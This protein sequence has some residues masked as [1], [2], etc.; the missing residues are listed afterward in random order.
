MKKLRLLCINN[1]ATKLYL[2]TGFLGAGKTTFLKQFVHLFPREKLAILINE[3][4]KEDVDSQLLSQLKASMEEIHSG[5]IFCAC[6]LEQFE[7][8]LNRLLSQRP[9]TIIIETSGLS[10]PSNLREVLQD[11]RQTQEV[12]YRGCICVVDAVNFVKVYTTALAARKQISV[13]DT[14]VLNKIDM[15]VPESK[16]NIITAL[17][18]ARPAAPVMETSRGLIPASWK[19]RLLSPVLLPMEPSPHTRDLSVQ[20]YIISIDS[21]ISLKALQDFLHTF[22][23]VTHRI[24]GFVRIDDKLYL[25]SCVGEQLQITPHEGTPERINRLVVLAGQGQPALKAIRQAIDMRKDCRITL[26]R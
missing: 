10:D 6:R 26:E 19:N 11:V 17:H 9:D 15:A 22:A 4:G 12:D 5:S 25:V 8:A 2:I 14:V 24:K 20:S 23:A 3:F 13:C 21:P 18:A 16:A 7:Q 1:M